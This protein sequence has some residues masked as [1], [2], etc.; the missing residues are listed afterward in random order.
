[1]YTIMFVLDDPSQLDAVLTAWR[2][3]GVTGITIVESSSFHRRQAHL[4]GARY[5]PLLLALQERVEQ[6]SYTLFAAV[7]TLPLVEQCFAAT[8]QVVGDLREPNTGII[9]AWQVALA[10]GLD[11]REQQPEVEQ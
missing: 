5:I 4:L 10:R 6:E 1:M 7:P 9:V 8:E 2:T 11:K 3:V